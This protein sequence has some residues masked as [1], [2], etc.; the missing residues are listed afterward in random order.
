MARTQGQGNPKWTRDET[1]LA[2]NLYLECNGSIPSRS[3]PRIRELS[4]LLNRLPFHSPSARKSSFRNV[5]GIVFNLQNLR[6]VA[7]GKGLGNVSEMHRK[8]WAEFGSKP[9]ILQVLSALIRHESKANAILPIDVDGDE[10][11]EGRILTALHKTRERDRSLRRRFLAIRRSA[12]QLTCEMCQSAP[13]LSEELPDDTVLEVHH[14]MPIGMAAER[15]TRLS[16]LALLCANCHR[17]LHRMISVRKRW[18]S[19][20]DGR[21]VVQVPTVSTLR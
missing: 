13:M 14:V 8:V 11:S 2:L 20:G 5:D 18:V 21:S 19:V 15:K 1:I 12:G 3:D 10:F 9:E 16:E 6:K 4:D 17:I 7:T